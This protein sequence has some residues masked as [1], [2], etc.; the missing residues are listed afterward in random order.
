MIERAGGMLTAKLF[1]ADV[2]G[3]VI[4]VLSLQALSY[5][6]SSSLSDTDTRYF[7]S[8]CLIAAMISFGL[9]KSRLK[10]YQA[11]AGIVALGGIGVWILGASLTTPLLDLG[12]AILKVIQE[13]IPQIVPAIKTHTAIDMTLIDT[14]HIFDAWKVVADASSALAARLQSWLTGLN[15]KVTINDALIRSMVWALIMWLFSA[16]AGWFA[17]QRKAI[18][19]LLPSIFLLALIISYSE[20]KVETLW[21]MVTALLVLMGVWNY[22]NHTQQWHKKSV[23]YSDSIRY[24]VTQAVA[25]LT[26][27][28]GSIS[29]ITPSVSLQDMRDFVR[30]RN[31]NET[32]DVLGI[33]EQPASSVQ[34]INTPKP[35]MPRDHLLTGGFA[36]S[37]NI[38]MT[39]KTGELPPVPDATFVERAPKYYWRSTVYDK[40]VSTGWVTSSSHPQRY[41]SN[42]P[43]IPGLLTGYKLLHMKVLM[44]EPEGKLFW[45]G[46]LFSA[47]TPFT[48]TWRIKPQ[49]DLFA[50]QSALLRADLFAVTTNATSYQSESYV[51]QAT[52]EQLHSAPTEYPEDILERY[53]TLPS[54]VPERVHRLAET[55]TFQIDNPYDKAKA[56]EEYLRAYPYDLDIP[57]PPEGQDVADYFLFDLKRG[58]CDYYATAM[59]VLARASGL[60][61]RFVSGYSS[62][63]YDPQNAEYIVRE[64]NAHSWAEIYFPGIGWVEFE[65]TASQ[66]EI[67][68][69]ED[70]TLAPTSQNND[71]L[72]SNLLTRFRLEKLSTWILPLLWM[73]LLIILYFTVIERWLYLRLA[74]TTAVERIQQRLYRLGRPLA[75]NRN[76]AETA[77]EFMQKLNNK[78]EEI[79]YSSRIRKL[80]STTQRDVRLLT[81]IYQT[82]LFKEHQTNGSDVKLALQTWKRLRWR[83]VVARIVLSI[84]NMRMKKSALG[85][86]P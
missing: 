53:F 23:D 43:V 85:I 58:Y 42:T 32:A 49:S 31:R 4:V 17:Q 64:L 6:V 8:I 77:H 79:K 40:Y 74:P 82:F 22:K 80:F 65:P 38:V 12:N 86:Q 66:P 37:Q 9:S 41:A 55:I 36:Q 84:K 14:S 28:I 11:S 20:Y 46:I 70:S 47:D 45:S 62:G 10:W 51:P 33:K 13:I 27:A 81:N 73:G 57:A 83:L 19:S 39:V 63:T 21:F 54:T 59:V 78:I 18:A 71:A 2:V 75:G 5:G 67:N 56:I 50:D 60:P 52:I 30:D 34:P 69:L 29:F 76:H 3:L 25:F 16:G 26:L 24:D 15:R 61:A 48:A 68:R 35:S 7:F 44:L 1:T 72:A